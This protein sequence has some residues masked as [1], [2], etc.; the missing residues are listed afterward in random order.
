MNSPA[1]PL[2]VSVQGGRRDEDHEYREAAQDYP[3][4]SEPDG[5]PPGFQCESK[6]EAPHC[7]R[8]RAGRAKAAAESPCIILV[9]I[10]KLPICVST[11][12]L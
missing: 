1:P 12:L 3:H 4:Y 7:S 8:L 5:R 6:G 10:H 2:R 9:Y 11:K